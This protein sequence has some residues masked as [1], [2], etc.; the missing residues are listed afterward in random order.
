MAAVERNQLFLCALRNDLGKSEQGVDWAGEEG[1]WRLGHGASFLRAPRLHASVASPRPAGSAATI[2][3]PDPVFS[4]SRCALPMVRKDQAGS[5][6]RI[7][8]ISSL[9]SEH[10]EPPPLIGFDLRD[11]DNDGGQFCNLRVT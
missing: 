8:Q 2:S 1:P 10:L 4:I 3:L 11:L 9:P 7:E 5:L 6:Q